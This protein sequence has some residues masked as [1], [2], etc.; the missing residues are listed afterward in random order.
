[1]CRWI[2]YLWI[3]HWYIHIYIYKYVISSMW[4]CS[5]LRYNCKFYV[6]FIFKF[7]LYLTGTSSFC[8]FWE[9]DSSRSICWS[10]TNMEVIFTVLW[11]S[12]YMVVE[13]LLQ[14]SNFQFFTCY[15]L[16]SS[17]SLCDYGLGVCC[18]ILVGTLKCM[19]Y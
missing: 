14:S 19:V 12:I 7:S 11:H 9:D 17:L 18:T 15:F 13:I 16:R 8:S 4:K 10:E 6:G 1:M 2:I 3:V 5:F